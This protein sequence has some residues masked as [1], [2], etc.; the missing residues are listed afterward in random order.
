M[1]IP[2]GGA[3]TRISDLG[4]HRF[5]PVNVINNIVFASNYRISCEL[6]MFLWVLALLLEICHKDLLGGQMINALFRSVVQKIKVSFVVNMF[7]L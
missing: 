7:K 4:L 1:R 6:K 5:Q 3:C 2:L